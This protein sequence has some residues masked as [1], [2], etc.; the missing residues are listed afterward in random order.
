MLFRDHTWYLSYENGCMATDHWWWKEGVR[1]H[2]MHWH[3]TR[4][5]CWLAKLFNCI[6]VNNRFLSCSLMWQQLQV[7]NFY[8]CRR[9]FNMKYKHT[10]AWLSTY[11]LKFLF[12]FPD[13]LLSVFFSIK[14]IGLIGGWSNIVTHVQ[15]ILPQEFPGITFRRISP[16]RCWYG[17]IQWR[18]KCIIFWSTNKK[19]NWYISW[20]WRSEV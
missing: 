4:Q 17:A 12:K 9:A 19:E 7:K 14:L 5:M 13:Y 11:L 16:G 3:K 10:R 8:L 6:H 20:G 15:K 2:W 18:H 1:L